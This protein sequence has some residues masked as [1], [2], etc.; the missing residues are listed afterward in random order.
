[1]RNRDSYVK[2]EDFLSDD[3]FQKW[4]RFDI[5][6]SNWSE[7]T[8]ENPRRA[9]MVEEARLWI[10]A[11]AVKETSLSD[12]ETRM[13]LQKVWE[14]IEGPNEEQPSKAIWQLTWFRSAAAILLVGLATLLYYTDLSPVHRN[15][16]ITYQ[17]LIR[18]D[19]NGLIEQTNNSNKPQ[20]ITL[21]DASS[22]LLQPKSKLSYPK[23]FT[24]NERKVY[25]SGEAF[26]EISKDANRAFYV[27]A[28]ETV[29]KVFGTS[30]RVVAYANQPNVEV[31]VRTGKVSVSSN[32]NIRNASSEEVTL[33]PNQAAR[34]VRKEQLFEK[35]LDITQDKPLLAATNTM[36]Q[37]SFDFKD[38]PVQQI[39]KT[40]E[41]AYLITIDFPQE[42]LKNC[43]LTTSLVDEPLPEKLK[44]IC[45]SLGNNS[46]YEMNGNYI[47]IIT[48]GC[49]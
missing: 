40:L 35:I 26:F 25:L 45:E 20:L 31:L 34:F 41:Q 42:K 3:S 47:K 14:N 36:E 4:I 29:T 12:Q 43:Y 19:S 22:V 8:V 6:Q 1:M 7:W 27:Y 23:I 21:S 9:K 17:E 44:I 46:R 37:L 24:E 2:I 5:D 39:F 30:F 49:K 33:L 18:K 38:I 32:Q 48:N 28:N 10:L 16:T 11:M 13:A 15:T